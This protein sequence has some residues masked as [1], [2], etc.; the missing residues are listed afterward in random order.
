MGGLGHA[1]PGIL[2]PLRLV[3]KLFLAVSIAICQPMTSD[4]K[5]VNGMVRS[6][7]GE[8]LC[9]S[10]DKNSDTRMFNF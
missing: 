7:K 9:N 6:R 3:L 5:V 4:G 2:E 8:R 10:V 1:F